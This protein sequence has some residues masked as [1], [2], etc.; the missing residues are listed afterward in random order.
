MIEVRPVEKTKD[1]IKVLDH[2]QVKP[3]IGD[4]YTKGIDI[5][6]TLDSPIIYLGAYENNEI[7][8]IIAA[9]QIHSVIYDM[10][11]AFLPEYWGTKKPLNAG[12]K[13]IDWLKKNTKAKKLTGCTPMDNKPALI[14]NIKIGFS[15]EGVNRSC[16]MLDGKM[17]DQVYFG[18]EI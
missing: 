16:I 6:R 18:M 9:V 8:G 2:P 11:S 13:A 3:L 7:L 5:E 12:Q 10:H 15:I 14:Y 4:D 17:K 1:L